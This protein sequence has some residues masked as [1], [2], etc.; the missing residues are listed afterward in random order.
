MAICHTPSLIGIAAHLLLRL[1][2]ITFQ[3]VTSDS[4]FGIRSA[5]GMHRMRLRSGGDSMGA[6]KILIADDDQESRNLL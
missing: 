5:T 1:K 6:L 2:T 4:K 3:S